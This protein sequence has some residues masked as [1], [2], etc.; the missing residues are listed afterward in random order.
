MREPNSEDLLP[1]RAGESWRMWLMTGARRGPVDRRRV[2]GAHVG[3]KRMLVEGMAIRGDTAYTWK[4]FSDAMVRQSVG[5]AMHPLSYR[6]SQVVKLAYF[7]GLTNREIA[8]HMRMTEATVERRLRHAIEAISRF[9]E[10][11]RGFGHRVLLGLALWF[12][13][14]T[15]SD[16]MHS[17]AQGV[18]IATAA[19][20]I[21][22]H[23]AAIG[24]A[25]PSAPAPPA[26]THASAPPAPVTA[27]VPSPTAPVCAT[28][29][30]AADAP[31][32]IPQTPAVQAPSVQVPSVQVPT[33][34]VPTVQLPPLPKTP[35]KVKA[36]L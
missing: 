32:A 5:D 18:V 6:D 29:S 27:P 13:G 11:G 9:V 7:G 22:T 33:V 4:E 2:R 19:A 36:V 14:K 20:V 28:A 21:A 15:A 16:A 35:V 3:I 31:V 17:A 30:A 26:T 10:R 1:N 12:S 25:H 24:V 23:P 8:G 34:Q